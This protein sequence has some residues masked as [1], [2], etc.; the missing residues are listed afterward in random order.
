MIYPSVSYEA[1]VSKAVEDMEQTLRSGGAA[2]KRKQEMKKAAQ[3][4]KEYQK[5]QQ[6]KEGSVMTTALELTAVQA[7]ARRK[8]S[9]LLTIVNE[10]L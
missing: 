5:Q 2:Y 4:I 1:S 8:N 9:K 6:V 3:R 7:K 10:K